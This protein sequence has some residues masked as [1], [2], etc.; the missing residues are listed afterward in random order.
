MMENE[1]ADFQRAAWPDGTT[2]RGCLLTG[3]MSSDEAAFMNG[4]IVPLEGGWT[5][6]Q[7]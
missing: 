1:L 6:N 5:A 7:D 2:R 4:S 3:Y